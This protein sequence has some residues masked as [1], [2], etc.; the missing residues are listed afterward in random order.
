M[1][2]S[3]GQLGLLIIK[4]ENPVIRSGP[5]HQRGHCTY[6]HLSIMR[7][8][9]TLLVHAVA[10]A[11]WLLCAA[12]TIDL[13]ASG[14]LSLVNDRGGQVTYPSSLLQAGKL[15][16]LQ[17]S[18]SPHY[19]TFSGTAPGGKPPQTYHSTVCQHLESSA[20]S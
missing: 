15:L 6:V 2:R 19:R 16:A 14:L 7:F 4:Q 13:D 3:I 10:A 9:S 11:S 8:H 12:A 18:A 20:H 5:S 1:Q 17:A